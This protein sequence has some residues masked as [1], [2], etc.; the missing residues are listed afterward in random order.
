M[1]NSSTLWKTVATA[2][3]NSG[4]RKVGSGAYAS[5]PN[6]RSIG[7][8]RE[9]IAGCD[10][11]SMNGWDLTSAYRSSISIGTRLMLTAAGP[12]GVCQRKRNGNW[13]PA[14]CPPLQVEL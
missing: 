6:I 7:A 14:P 1:I 11:T 5:V 10:V 12:V 8:K 4:R 3:V 9:T 2:D 13:R